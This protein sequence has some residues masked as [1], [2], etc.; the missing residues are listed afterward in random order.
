MGYNTH[1]TLTTS[2]PLPEGELARLINADED[3]TCALKPDGHTQE[4]WKWYNHEDS[5]EAF[6]AAHPEVVFTLHGEGAE[7]GDVWDKYFLDGGLIYTKRL[8]PLK[9]IS[10]HWIRAWANEQKGQV[11]DLAALEE[12][13]NVDDTV[14]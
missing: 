6:S 8:E 14:A 4:G 2:D 5:L 13:T 7:P 12:S 9:K 10:P 3:A 1:Y 11:V